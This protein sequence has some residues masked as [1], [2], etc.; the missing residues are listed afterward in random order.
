MIGLFFMELN[1]IM[2]EYEV[3]RDRGTTKRK[4]GALL[5]RVKKE[6]RNARNLREAK[7]YK[8]IIRAIEQL[9]KGL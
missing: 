3:F 7:E 6:A 9:L 5:S 8:A 2:N 1:E 4:L